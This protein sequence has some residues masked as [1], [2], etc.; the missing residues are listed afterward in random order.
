MPVGIRT[1]SPGAN[2]L[3]NRARL[4]CSGT[5][6]SIGGRLEPYVWPSRVADGEVGAAGGTALDSGRAGP[7]TPTLVDQGPWGH[8]AGVSG[9]DHRVTGPADAVAGGRS[10]RHVGHRPAGHVAERSR[11]W[12]AR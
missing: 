7:A 9:L 10:T 6:Q 1:P 2:G 5:L 12:V 3:S 4:S 11:R 8:R